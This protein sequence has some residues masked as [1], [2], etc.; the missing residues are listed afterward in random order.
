MKLKKILN[1]L[2]P[3]E[4][5]EIGILL[6]YGL[7]GNAKGVYKL[8]RVCLDLHNSK[9]DWNELDLSARTFP[10]KNLEYL[11]TRL[12]R[13][14]SYIDLYLGLQ[15]IKREGW[16]KNLCKLEELSF[17]KWETKFSRDFNQ[18]SKAVSA[19]PFTFQRANSTQVSTNSHAKRVLIGQGQS[20]TKALFEDVFRDLDQHFLINRLR[21]A[22]K[23]LSQDIVRGTEHKAYLDAGDK[24]IELLEASLGMDSDP[25]V[26][27]YIVMFKVVQSCAKAENTTEDDSTFI[28]AKGLLFDNW[29]DLLKYDRKETQDLFSYL[30]NYAIRRFNQK[31]IQFSEDLKKFYDLLLEND[32]L[33]EDGKI[34]SQKYKNISSLFLTMRD[35]EFVKKFQ[36]EY[37]SKIDGIEKESIHAFCYARFYYELGDLKKAEE[38]LNFALVSL[39]RHQNVHLEMEIYGLIIR[40][41]YEQNELDT[42]ADCI[43]RLRNLISSSEKI[44]P[45]K[46]KSYANFLIRISEILEYHENQ[47]ITSARQDDLLPCYASHWAKK[48]LKALAERTK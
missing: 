12:V 42:V 44:D 16:V 34:A 6:E 23:A 3:K 19:N 20:R 46:Q 33:T 24:V 43:P 4:I 37:E 21:I 7:L 26:A 5:S 36:I 18:A 25:I 9:P 31:E 27:L 10:E 35:Y 14:G 28:I 15:V 38:K 1:A 39:P 13:L 48:C 29:K 41:N 2:K 47:S 17:R 45:V 30:I 11:R 22:C 32:L 8:Y 40:V